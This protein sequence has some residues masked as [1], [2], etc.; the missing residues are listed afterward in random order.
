MTEHGFLRPQKTEIVPVILIQKEGVSGVLSG[1]DN[2]RRKYHVISGVLGETWELRSRSG[3][4]FGEDA[5]N[6]G[7]EN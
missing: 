1:G 5:S 2:D 6:V 3:V 7:T 4:R